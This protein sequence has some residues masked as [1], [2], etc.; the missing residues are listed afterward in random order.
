MKDETGKKLVNSREQIRRDLIN[1]NSSK[2]YRKEV[3]FLLLLRPL[4]GLFWL[5]VDELGGSGENYQ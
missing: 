1:S 2:R 3:Q 5:E 4:E